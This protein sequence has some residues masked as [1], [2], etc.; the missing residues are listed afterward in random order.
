M[1]FQTLLARS[2]AV[3]GRDVV[4]TLINFFIT[5]FI[6]NKLGPELFG[7]WIGCL[8]FLLMCDL[9][10][11]LK[12]DQLIVY[13]SKQYPKNSYLYLKVALLNL[14][15]ALVG[16]ILVF[17]FKDSIIG[18]FN[19]TS[20]YF[21]VLVFINFFLSI[22]GNII[23]YIFLAESRYNLYNL[24]ILSQAIINVVCIL[25]LFHF[26]D[27]SIFL[28]LISLTVS[29]IT[30]VLFFIFYKIIDPSKNN[31]FYSGID[32]NNRDILK[33]GGY[34]YVSSAVKTLSDQIPKLFAI[35]FLGPIYVG[36]L[37]LTQ[38][39]ITLVNRL[40]I[41]INTILFPM[42][43]KDGDDEL[44]KTLAVIRVLMILL[45]PIFTV[46]EIYIPVF[47]YYLYGEEYS[48]AAQFIRILLPFV[49][50]GVPGLILSSYF[51]AKGRFKDL[52]IINLTAL[53]SAVITLYLIKIISIEYAPIFSLCITFMTIT[54][55]SILNILDRISFIDILPKKHDY[56]MIVKFFKT[57][58]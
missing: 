13:Y 35:T 8:T 28:P 18:F 46:L 48:A 27:K 17:V 10:F 49:Y 25:M 6:A 22:F 26:Y 20:Y 16:G 15:V 56:N 32:I 43:V 47:I 38:L 5:T 45:V 52:F 12:I 19:F 29:W 39:L 41:A 14:Y 57:K 4:V 1:F 53:S 42:L 40:P 37:G 2:S 58:N 9:L 44:F 54:L 50:I 24:C 31:N 51:S 55:M 30:V 11:R 3:L 33:K 36:Y 23:F 7:L 34:I 21:L